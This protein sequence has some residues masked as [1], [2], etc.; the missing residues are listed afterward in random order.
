MATDRKHL[1]METLRKRVKEMIEKKKSLLF[2]VEI[3]KMREKQ[4]KIL[5]ET[6]SL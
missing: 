6:Q 4:K 1:I 2:I 3:A 5:L